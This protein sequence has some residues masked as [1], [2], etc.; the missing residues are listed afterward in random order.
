MGLQP[1]APENLVAAVEQDDADVGS[2]T[3][4]VEHNQTPIF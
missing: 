2:E 1:F 4:T 3:L